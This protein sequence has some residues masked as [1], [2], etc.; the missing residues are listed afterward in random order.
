[1]IYSAFQCLGGGFE[2][3]KHTFQSMS[4]PKYII[5]CDYHDII[6]AKYT[7]R[8]FYIDVPLAVEMPNYTGL[9]FF[10]KDFTKI[11]FLIG[12]QLKQS[13]EMV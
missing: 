6:M 12:C 8:V 2:Q 11:A 4:W 1:M 10:S 13:L 9:G 5:I 3:Y 7:H